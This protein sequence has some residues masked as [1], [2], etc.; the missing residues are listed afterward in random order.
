MQVCT[1]Q[2]KRTWCCSKYSLKG[3]QHDDTG[4]DWSEVVKKGRKKKNVLV[5]QAS[6]QD[7]HAVDMKKESQALTGIQ[8]TDSSF[9]NGGN[10]VMNFENENTREE[11]AKRLGRVEKFTTKNV[12]N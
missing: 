6:E 9:T 7:K 3:E 8:I 12:K 10:V 1:E 4:A 5:V 11:A 2:V